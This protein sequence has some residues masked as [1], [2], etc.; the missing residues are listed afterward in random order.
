MNLPTYFNSNMTF[1]FHTIYFIS[2]FEISVISNSKQD[3]RQLD[4]TVDT[5]LELSIQWMTLYR[6]S[7]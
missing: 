3:V 2:G 4:G 1:H 6:G 7:W 5:A